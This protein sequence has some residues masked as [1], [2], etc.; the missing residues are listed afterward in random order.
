MFEITDEFIDQAG[1][2]GL[3]GEPREKM[4]QN[5]SESVGSRLVARLAVLAGRGG[6]D[7]LVALTDG[8]VELAR[9]ILGELEPSYIDSDRYHEAKSVAESLEMGDD[10]LL[11]EYATKI[12]LESKNIDV[13]GIV[14]EIMAEVQDELKMIFEASL[15]AV[16]NQA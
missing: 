16:T 3:T 11:C 6:A 13:D 7:E 1:F 12:W 15:N 10:E 8:D 14:S 2:A 5:I 4:K 9:K